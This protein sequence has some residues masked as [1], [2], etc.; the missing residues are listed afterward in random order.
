MKKITMADEDTTPYFIRN[1]CYFRFTYFDTDYEYP[2]ID[3]WVYL[4]DSNTPELKDKIPADAG[5]LYF[6]DADSYANH[7]FLNS[8]RHK[9]EDGEM[10]VWQISEADAKEKLLH[11]DGLIQALINCKKK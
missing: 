6:Q 1:K 7:G 8:K 4:G 5:F 9:L 10:R 11:F 2:A 3:T